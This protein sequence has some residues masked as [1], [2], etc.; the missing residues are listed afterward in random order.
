MVSLAH[1]CA[2]LSRQA[3]NDVPDLNRIRQVWIARYSRNGTQAFVSRSIAGHLQLNRVVFDDY[4]FLVFRGTDEIVDIDVDRKYTKADFQF[5]GRVH[6]GFLQALEEIRS[7]LQEIMIEHRDKKWIFTGHSLGAALALLAASI[8][9]PSAAYLYG[10]PRVGNKVFLKTIKCLVLNFRNRG[11]VVTRVPPPTSFIQIWSSLRHNRKPTLYRQ[12][13]RIIRLA[14]PSLGHSITS[15]EAATLEPK[16]NPW[17]LTYSPY[18]CP[19]PTKQ[20]SSPY[21]NAKS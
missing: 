3:Y 9:N 5:G 7:D 10:C 11:D 21:Q 18:P 14:G 6:S 13:K 4:M 16:G 19:I 12:A 17:W 2:Y 15:Y 8:W 1:T 20:D